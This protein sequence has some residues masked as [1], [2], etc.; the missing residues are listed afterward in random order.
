MLTVYVP[1]PRMASSSLPD[2]KSSSMSYS[3]RSKGSSTTLKL[4]TSASNLASGMS[5]PAFRTD[6]QRRHL[7]EVQYKSS[8]SPLNSAGS[9]AAISEEER[10]ILSN[11]LASL[12]TLTSVTSRPSRPHGPSSAVN[13]DS[14]KSSSSFLTTDGSLPS[15]PVSCWRSPPASS[16]SPSSTNSKSASTRA[17]KSRKAS[18][19]IVPSL[20]EISDHMSRNSSTVTSPSEIMLEISDTLHSPLKES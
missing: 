10:H 14:I 11:S 16:T 7:D 3:Y 18:I 6:C 2:K 19:S 17:S 5:R 20:L 4:C 15:L 8:Q 13:N 9:N 1:I 12:T